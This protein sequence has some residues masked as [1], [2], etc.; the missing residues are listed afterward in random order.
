[1][2][3]KKAEE[4]ME[5]FY[6]EYQED[7]TGWSFWMSPP[8]GS[9]DFYEAY[10]I[11]GEEA[12]FLKFDSVY[13]PNPVGVGARLDIE[14]DQLVEDLPEFGY[15]KFSRGETEKFLKNLPVPEEYDSR[16]EFQEAVK[17]TRDE[18]VEKAL[19]KDPRPFE[20]LDEPG[21]IAAIGP[22]SSKS[23]LDYISDRQKEL[24]KELAKKL[25]RII[26][27]EYPGYR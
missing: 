13:S 8:P 4:I 6:Q 27:R 9:D 24:R 15:R 17:S 10:I 23:P 22:Y 26:D 25:N 14:R 2:K 12:F 19:D 21:E 18:M 3:K 11:H 20:P 1:M 5:D 16:E 7:P